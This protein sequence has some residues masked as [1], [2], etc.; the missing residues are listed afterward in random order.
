MPRILF[1]AL[2]R[3]NRSP[4]QRFRYEQYIGFLEE[5]GWECDFSFLIPEHLDKR[6]YA[7]GSYF[8][9]LWVLLSSYLKRW[10]DVW[11]ANRYDVIFVQREAMMIRTTIFERRFS[12]SRAALVF[13]FDDAI[14]LPNVS[15]GN[16]NLQWL[17][18]P[19]K[20]KRI[21][22]NA[23]L[24]FAG[25]SF[26]YAYA[27]QFQERVKLIPT[28]ID[29]TRHVPRNAKPVDNGTV[30]IGWTGSSTTIQHFERAI[31]FLSI[32]KKRYGQKLEIRVV[33]AD[34]ENKELD[35]YGI[36]WNETTEIADLH[37]FDIGIMPLPNDEWAKGKCGLKGLQYMA[38]AIPCVMS[39]VGVNTEIV[40][41]GED[42]FLATEE[43]EWVEICARLIEDNQLREMVGKKARTTVEKR[44]SVMANR[45]LYL[46]YL[47]ELLQ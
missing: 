19:E 46:K 16:Q 25:N 12:R 3:P 8:V 31:P 26:L 34:Y 13:D 37:H 17:K 42:G 35:I 44:Y 4:S 38:L 23:Q 22:R 15:E 24:V 27:R 2:H 7:S 9:K 32:L 21:I 11:K 1:V 43:S 18:S 39:P 47:N 6:F 33:G 20:T 29:T 36:P 10:N 45:T 41:H 30:C 5:N 14:W 40:T 28:T